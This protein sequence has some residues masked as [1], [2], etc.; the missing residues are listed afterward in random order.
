[1]FEVTSAGVL[2]AQGGSLS[3]IRPGRTFVCDEGKPMQWGTF[4]YPKGLE[5]RP[6]VH[7]ERQFRYTAPKAEMFVVLQGRMQVRVYNAQ[8]VEITAP[9]GLVM[10]AG[11][12][13]CCYAGGH[14]FKM[15]DEPTVFLEI[16]LGPYNGVGDDKE[17][18]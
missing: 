7:K 2:L 1:M 9:D 4:R 13:L 3:G 6:H 8:K 17:K 5:V 12:F 10:G 18:F 15:L 11:D 14:G 16:G